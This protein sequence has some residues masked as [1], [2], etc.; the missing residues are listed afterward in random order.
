MTSLSRRGPR[1]SHLRTSRRLAGANAG[2]SLS[3]RLSNKTGACSSRAVS[4]PTELLE[5][6][7][8]P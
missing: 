6:T 7:H 3:G 1:P 8:A 2:L 5:A 4:M